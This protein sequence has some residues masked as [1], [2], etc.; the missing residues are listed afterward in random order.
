MRTVQGLEMLSPFSKHT[1]YKCVSVSVC[2][3]S[4]FMCVD[5]ERGKRA[6]GDPVLMQS[7]L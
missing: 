1:V 7:V 5:R 6:G 2:T 4:V 3:V